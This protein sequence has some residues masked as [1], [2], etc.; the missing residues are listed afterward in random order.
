MLDLLD[1]FGLVGRRVPDRDHAKLVRVEINGNHKTVHAWT[2]GMLFRPH[3][4][5]A[6]DPV[7]VLAGALAG[8]VLVSDGN[9]ASHHIPSLVFFE[10][11][12]IR[13]NTFP[14]WTF[15]ES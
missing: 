15:E 6:S 4:N 12:S 9:V 11:A 10:M 2:G 14:C 1:P 7:V 5:T 13:V 8:E 3:C